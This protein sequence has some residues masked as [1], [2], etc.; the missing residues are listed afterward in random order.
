MQLGIPAAEV[1]M[2]TINDELLLI[3][4]GILTKAGILELHPP[5]GGEHS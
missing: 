1:G 2:A 3:G 5:I 4:K